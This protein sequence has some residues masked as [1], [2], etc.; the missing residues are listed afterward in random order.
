MIGYGFMGAAHS[1]GWRVAPRFFDLPA[2]PEMTLLVGRNAEAAKAAAEKFGWAETATDWRDAVARDDI[3][4][5]DI[6]TPG[7]SHVDIAIAALEAGK[8]VLCEKPLAN[9]VEEARAMADAAEKAAAKGVYAMVGFTYRRVP[10]ATFARDLVASGAIGEVRQ[11]RANYLQDWLVDPQ[12]PLAWRLQK[13]LAGSGALGDIG[14][15][16]IDLAQ[17]I[18]GQ[19]LTSVSGMLETFVKQRPILA[20]VSGLSGTASDELGDVTVDDL[21]LFTGRFDG[22]AVGSFEATRMSTGRKNAFRI[23]VSGSKGAISFDLESLNELGFYDATAPADRQGFTRILVTEP[24]HPYMEAWWPTG[25]ML[26][27]EHGFSHQARDFVVSVVEG[28]Q[29]TPSFADGLQVQQVLEA[30]EQSA[31]SGSSWV[32]T[33]G[34]D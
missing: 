5:I 28:S 30:V 16:A 15:H 31:E 18:T 17:F 32:A 1:Q 11:V 27:Y 9:T 19:K 3:D 33:S 34:T 14:A 10:A 29:P 20:E 7:D 26:G 6:V 12:V 4:V 21:A 8:H 23:E 13:H 22:G 24:Q 2:E 25:H